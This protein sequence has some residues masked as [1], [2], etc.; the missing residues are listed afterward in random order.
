ME[1]TA[2]GGVR[3]SRVSLNAAWG[4]CGLVASLSREPWG[5]CWPHTSHGRTTN[6]ELADHFIS[7][8]LPAYR[9]AINASSAA[10]PPSNIA[11]LSLQLLPDNK[12]QKRLGPSPRRTHCNNSLKR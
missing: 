10:P 8:T 12:G 5:G 6:A 4:R 11:Q 9:G 1:V 2:E 7:F 3:G